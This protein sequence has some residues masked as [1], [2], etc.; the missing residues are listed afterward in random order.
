M[1]FTP[2]SVVHVVDDAAPIRRLVHALLTAEGFE[3]RTAADGR[4]FLQNVTGSTDARCCAV[5]DLNLPDIN[6]LELLA[7]L[8][9]LHLRIPTIVLTGTGDIAAAV[10][11]MKAGAEDFLEKPVDPDRLVNAVRAA[12]QLDVT[13]AAWRKLAA[14]AELRING[15]T[16]RERQVLQ[17]IVAGANTKSIARELGISPRTVE[18]HRMHVM[19]KM[20]VTSLSELLRLCFAA[21]L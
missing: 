11:A 4:E 16:E 9:E 18:A 17:G 8:H 21:D 2:I 3:V 6:G 19:S 20:K 7:R 13:Q 5:L 10:A 12:L 15:L 14:E 1:P